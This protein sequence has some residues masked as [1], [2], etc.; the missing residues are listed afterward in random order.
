MIGEA[1]VTSGAMQIQ[2]FI[3]ILHMAIF[4]LLK[5]SGDPPFSEPSSEDNVCN[6]Y[7]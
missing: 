3:Y 4:E 6:N 5:Y 2:F 7:R 1:S